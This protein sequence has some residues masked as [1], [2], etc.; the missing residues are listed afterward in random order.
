[1]EIKCE[2]KRDRVRRILINPLVRAGMRK[3]GSMRVA[4][5]EEMLVRLADKL[6]YLSDANLRGLVPLITRMARGKERNRWPDEV[7]I[8]SWAFELQSPPPRA[9]DY[10]VS[11]M[12]SEAGRRARALGYHVELFM[13]ARK[14]GPPF[15]KIHLARV[16]ADAERNR[17]EVRRVTGAIERGVAPLERRQWLDW[18]LRHEVEALAIMDSVGE[19]EAA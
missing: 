11:V 13:A 16:M 2:T 7:S 5:Y 14:L 17:A 9:C 1:M 3:Q 12:R 4:E 6:A 19:G 10:V 8:V 18:W 15:K